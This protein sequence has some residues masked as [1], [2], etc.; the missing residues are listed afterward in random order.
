MISQSRVYQFEI[1]R[2]IFENLFF[3]DSSLR[4]TLEKRKK[5]KISVQIKVPCTMEKEATVSFTFKHGNYSSRYHACVIRTTII[6][7]CLETTQSQILR[8]PIVCRT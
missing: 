6:I 5:G 8:A 7:A 4:V 2:E 1:C 3:L